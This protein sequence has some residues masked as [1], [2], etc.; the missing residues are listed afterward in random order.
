MASTA[1]ERALQSRL[2]A[3]SKWANTT[4]RSGATAP[5][6]AA[7]ESRFGSE[8][9]PDGTLDPVE[10]A[11]RAASARAAYFS[12]LA[13][14]SAQS[15]RRASDAHKRAATDEAK[16]RAE[17]A[18]RIAEADAAAEA[19]DAELRAAEI[20]PFEVIVD[21]HNELSPAESAATTPAS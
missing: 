12:R 1:T 14:Q 6:R 18:K 11:Q 7:F 13:L 2:A 17:N 15:R 19:A 4:D 8:V 16:V 20:A 3:H 5:G 10:R 9:D 21:P